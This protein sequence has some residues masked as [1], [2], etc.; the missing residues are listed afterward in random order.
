MFDDAKHPIELGASIFVQVNH[1]LVNA[2]RDLG[3]SMNTANYKRPR[4]A[5]DSIGIWDGKQFVFTLKD[6]YSWWNLGR[7][8]WRYGLAPLRTQNLMK[9]I[10]GKFLRLYEE[11]FFPF[12]SLSE[13]TAL[14]E[15][16][17][18]TSSTG[19]EF[20]SKNQIS[21]QF[22][23]E[24][25]QASTRVNYGQNL[26]LMHGLETMVCMATD[27]A[28][29]IDGGNWRIFDGAI[30]AARAD[31]KL[32]T[33]VTGITRNEDGTTRVIARQANGL[34]SVGSVEEMDFD[35]LI[36]AG[37]LQYS[38]ISITPPLEHVPDEIPYVNLYVTLFASPHRL[39]P[40]RFGL[41][42]ENEVAPETIL[43]TL[44]EGVDLG[45][46]PHGVGPAQ[47][48][49]ISTLQTVEHTKIVDGNEV[50]ELHYV[51]KI[52]SPERPT[53]EFIAEVL[54]ID[55]PTSTSL[56]NGSNANT[57]I[58][59]LP[60]SE[61]SWFHEKFWN[62]YPLLYPRVTFEEINLAP[63]LWYTSGIESFIS[64]M[65][66]SALMGRNVARLIANSWKEH[67]SSS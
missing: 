12:R 28:V 48:W 9:K 63:G 51:Y 37:P 4:E 46:N 44:P 45:Q 22:A 67:A 14:V 2:T 11:P 5:A 18:A 47:F 19:D 35:E 31:C 41:V 54:G 16:L 34:G 23:R 6:S 40:K 52:F 24:I 1:N 65:E 49:S 62:P 26:P 66:T 3:L 25:I 32:N 29:S 8:F 60:S 38:G 42:G 36:I 21:S 57:T 61:I 50:T 20:L 58:G 27:G 53:A 43:T 55:N 64:T 59:D 56:P 33:T 7:L 13:A 30:K 15:L 10:V 39:S 17:E